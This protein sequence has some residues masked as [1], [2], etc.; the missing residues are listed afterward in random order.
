[1]QAQV[2]V[3]PQARAAA[4]D[5]HNEDNQ[6]NNDIISSLSDIAH[7]QHPALFIEQAN[8]IEFLADMSETDPAR[9][10]T[11]LDKIFA[12]PHQHEKLLQKERGAMFCEDSV[13]HQDDIAEDWY[14]D[15]FGHP[16]G[17][18]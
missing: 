2:P 15:K 3:Q 6:L 12:Q 9:Y 16:S 8:R 5:I 1:M 11:I 7:N 4:H 18:T 13:T 17:I 10:T 14:V